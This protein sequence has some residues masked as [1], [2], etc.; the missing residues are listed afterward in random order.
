MKKISI[1]IISLLMISFVGA[2]VLDAPAKKQLFAVSGCEEPYCSLFGDNYY[3][4]KCGDTTYKYYCNDGEVCENGM[5]VPSGTKCQ[6]GWKTDYYCGELD[7]SYRL[8]QKQNADCSIT[9]YKY[10]CNAGEICQ[11]G[12]C[13]KEQQTCT[14]MYITDYYCSDLSNA[15][16]RRWQ[17]EN[18]DIVTYKWNCDDNE[19]CENGECVDKAKACESKWLTDYYCS[20]LANARLRQKQNTD[21]SVTTNKYDCANDE[22]CKD[23]KCV[24]DECTEQ[25]LGDP[26]CSE[27]ANSYLV[28]FQNKDCSTTT[29]KYDCDNDEVCE[30]GKCVTGNPSCSTKPEIPC[31]DAIWEDY[32]KCS[33][34]T[35][36]C[37]ECTQDTDCEE[38]QVCNNNKC[39]SSGEDN[40]LIWIILGVGVL[41]LVLVIIGAVTK[42]KSSF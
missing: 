19:K 17:R 7:N 33:W 12:A 15:K 39:T 21:C 34:N 10:Y 32:P 24:K 8:R 9:T 20:S 30:D 18:C 11:N 13:V 22:V 36:S 23:G 27:L 14:P 16:L 2:E 31:D 26:Y 42:K 3:L 5:C 28:R 29:K 40:N 35:G 38:N 6:E 1:F 4:K 37:K 41:G 25:Q